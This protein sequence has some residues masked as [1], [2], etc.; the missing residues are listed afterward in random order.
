MLRHKMMPICV[1]H[2][3]RL[4]FLKARNVEATQKPAE[5]NCLAWCERQQT[6]GASNLL[7]HRSGAV[8]DFKLSRVVEK[9]DRMTA[10]NAQGWKTSTEK[11]N[12]RRLRVELSAF[13][14]VLFIG[15]AFRGSKQTE[16]EKFSRLCSQFECAAI[17]FESLCCKS[18]Y[19]L[20][21]SLR[22]TRGFR[23]RR[24]FRQIKSHLKVKTKT[25][26]VA[27]GENQFRVARVR[28]FGLSGRHKWRHTALRVYFH[29]RPNKRVCTSA[30]LNLVEQ[31]KKSIRS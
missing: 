21:F 28:L 7:H 23:F 8:P 29:R 18:C 10:A 1:F 16:W 4:S 22:G 31:Q 6:C 17:N 25:W 9:K 20:L 26:S 27:V 13:A 24:S 3:P 15:K 19:F 12:F 5:W 11:L 30:C 2:V 14:G